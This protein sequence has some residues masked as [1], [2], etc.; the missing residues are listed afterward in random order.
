MTGTIPSE[1]GML[2]S[3]IELSLNNNSIKGTLPTELCALTNTTIYYDGSEIS[4]SCVGSSYKG[5]TFC[6]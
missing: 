3:L 1:M 6:N 5:G 2:S 4:C